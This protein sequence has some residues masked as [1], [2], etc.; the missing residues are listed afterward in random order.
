VTPYAGLDVLDKKQVCVS[1]FPSKEVRHI[2]TEVTSTLC[3][4]SCRFLEGHVVRGLDNG[5]LF[6]TASKRMANS[7]MVR[8]EG[9]RKVRVIISL[10]G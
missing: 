8:I 2:R 4:I 6:L 3:V 9:A 7:A 1:S 5:T 10:H